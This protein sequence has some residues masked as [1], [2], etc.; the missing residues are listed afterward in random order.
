M[1]ETLVPARAHPQLELGALDAGFE[2]FLAEFDELGAPPLRFAF[3][4]SLFAGAWIAPLLVR[5]LPPL[6][7]LPAGDRSAAL[8]AMEVSNVN[9]LRQ[10]MRI[11]KT[12]VALHYGAVPSVRKTIG[13]H[14]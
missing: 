12:V 11:L 9:A 2:E 6:S 4:L 1:V 10:L 8:S 14:A 13:Y 3:R 5:R 7:R